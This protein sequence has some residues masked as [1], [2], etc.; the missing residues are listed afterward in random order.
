MGS[1]LVSKLGR[2]VMESLWELNYRTWRGNLRHLGSGARFHGWIEISEPQH[3][4][5][6]DGVS[7]HSAYIQGAGGVTIGDYVHFGRNL[8]IYSVNHRFEGGQAI[9]YDE[10]LIKKPVKIGDYVWV[11]ANV[12]ISPGVSIGE[13]AIIALGS[14]VV[15]D[16]PPL[17]IAGGNPA[18][19]IRYRNREEFEKLKKEKR[20]M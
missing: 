18:S 9:P 11:G 7:L 17:A 3:V 16:I 2:F 19:V 12:S 8:S 13:G 6:G 15:K 1:G 10:V 20:F 4:S 14:V 5:I